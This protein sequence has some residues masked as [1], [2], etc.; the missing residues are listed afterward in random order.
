MDWTRKIAALLTLVLF[1]APALVRAE[2][3]KGL[4]RLGDP[5]AAEEVTGTIAA[6]TRGR[7]GPVRLV[8]NTVGG[9]EL[10]VLVAPDRTCEALGLSLRVGEEVELAGQMITTGE[11]PL[12]V[13]EAVLVDGRRIAVRDSGGDGAGL[14][15]A[16]PKPEGA[17]G[18]AEEGAEGAEA[19]EEPHAAGQ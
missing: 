13:T 1:C 3:R 16:G 19:E 2:A 5:A 17:G 11:R 14:A 10:L 18:D 8:V 4:P 12:F 7:K 6:S 9:G 15:P